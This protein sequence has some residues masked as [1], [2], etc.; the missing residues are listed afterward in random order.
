MSWDAQTVANGLFNHNYRVESGSGV[1][2]LF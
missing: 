2:V 1:L